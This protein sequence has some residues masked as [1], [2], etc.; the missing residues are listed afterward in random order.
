VKVLVAKY[1]DNVWGLR[2]KRGGCSPWWQDI[3]K[4]FGEGES[5]CSWFKENCKKS[6]GDGRFTSFWHE[7]WAEGH[8]MRDKFEL[9]FKLSEDKSAV[10]RDMGEWI[11][12]VW[13]WKWRWSR[14]FY[15]WERILFY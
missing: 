12:G 8:S 1:G 3:C 11:Q 2:N 5:S 15:V 13:V 7:R 6:L 4:F 10:I 9:F 14:D